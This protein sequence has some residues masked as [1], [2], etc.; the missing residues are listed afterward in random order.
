MKNKFKILLILFFIIL[1]TENKKEGKI[2][3]I[4]RKTKKKL[5]ELI[6]INNE[7][8]L[9][10]KYIM[11]PIFDFCEIFIKNL[12]KEVLVKI[13]KD[14]NL[15]EDD[16]NLIFSYKKS[17]KRKL[18][19]FLDNEKNS[20]YFDKLKNSF[21][22]PKNEKKGN[23]DKEKKQILDVEKE[24]GTKNKNFS[25][26]NDF[27]NNNLASNL[28]NIWLENQVKDFFQ[29]NLRTKKYSKDN[30]KFKIK[31]N[32]NFLLN[33]SGLQNNNLNI[34]QNTNKVNILPKN[35]KVNILPKNNKVIILVKNNK[36]N[37]L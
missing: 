2:K 24:D 6:G 30:K 32:K 35:N 3:N 28:V 20:E 12:K 16:D 13:E 9:G 22:N 11:E 31:K 5:F 1:K 27:A 7:D 14:F 23:S 8:D 15:N 19:Y 37:N 21:L 26:F 18:R 29:T 17:L 36:I 33:N 10:K 4:M 34:L 25:F